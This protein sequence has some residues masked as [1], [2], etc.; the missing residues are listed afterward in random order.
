VKSKP[1]GHVKRGAYY[2]RLVPPVRIS[3]LEELNPNFTHTYAGNVNIHLSFVPVSDDPRVEA[4]FRTYYF[5]LIHRETRTQLIVAVDV[6]YFAPSGNTWETQLTTI[7]AS[8]AKGNLSLVRQMEFA[9][10]RRVLVEELKEAIAHKL[11]D[12]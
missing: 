11:N 10:T 4:G 3:E 2:A 9:Q 1:V 12:F 5:G 6:P 8:L 7:D